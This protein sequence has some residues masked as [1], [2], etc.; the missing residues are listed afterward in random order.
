MKRMFWLAMALWTVTA[1][2]CANQRLLWEDPYQQIQAGP[3]PHTVGV[4]PT[5]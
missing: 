4:T 3:Q 2:G 1:V 5:P